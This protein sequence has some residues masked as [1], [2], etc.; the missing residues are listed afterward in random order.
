MALNN[1]LS[2]TLPIFS[3]CRQA[4]LLAS[5]TSTVPSYDADASRT[6]TTRIGTTDDS[7]E[8][9]GNG[10]STEIKLLAPT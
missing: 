6:T 2:S 10:R 5:Q 4:P 3:V 7:K 8:L 1:M 9:E